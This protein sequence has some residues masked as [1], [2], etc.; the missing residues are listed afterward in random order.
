LEFGYYKSF[1]EHQK[2]HGEEQYLK[3]SR[4]EDEDAERKRVDKQRI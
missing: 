4:L 2:E 1:E 3:R